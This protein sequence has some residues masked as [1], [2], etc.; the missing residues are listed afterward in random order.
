MLARRAPKTDLVAPDLQTFLRLVSKLRTKWEFAKDD[1]GGPWY[2]GQQRKHWTLIPNVVRLGCFDRQSED[3]IREEFA[4]RAPALSRYEN[5]PTGDWELYFLMQHYGAPT[6]LLDWTESPT[7]AL[8]FAVRDNPRHYDSAVWMLDPYEMNKRVIRKGEVICPSAS[9]VNPKDLNRVHGCGSAGP[10]SISLS[11]QSPFFRR[12]LQGE[13]AVKNPALPFTVQV[14][15]GSKHFP[16][17]QGH[18]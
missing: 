6:R 10:K 15:R 4:I 1:V 16:K 14:K 2:R 5:L 13:S 17:D 8:Y 7:I 18:V 12:T 3:E 9:G 11:F